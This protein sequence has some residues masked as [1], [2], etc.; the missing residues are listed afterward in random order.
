MTSVLPATGSATGLRLVAH[1]D[2]GGHGDGMQ[3][4]LDEP[5]NGLDPEGIR[6]LR[7]LLRSLAAQGRTVLVSSHL[8]SEMAQTAEHLVVIGQGRLLAE[9]TAADLTAAGAAGR[10]ASLEDVFL[11]LTSG[12]TSYRAAGGGAQGRA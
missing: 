5:A 1:H 4:L 7:S 10:D 3:L 12:V 9:G 2:L 6:W 8:I 11:A